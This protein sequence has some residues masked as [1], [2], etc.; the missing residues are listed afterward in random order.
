[1]RA[2][3]QK[4]SVPQPAPPGCGVSTSATA[5]TAAVYQPEGVNPQSV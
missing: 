2:T 5:E 1:M 3:P 4:G